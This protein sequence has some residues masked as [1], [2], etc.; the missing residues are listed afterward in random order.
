LFHPNILERCY[1]PPEKIDNEKATLTYKYDDLSKEEQKINNLKAMDVFAVGC[2]LLELI[3]G[4]PNPLFTYQKMISFR[5][6]DKNVLERLNQIQDE[7]L[8]TMIAKMVNIDPKERGT[9]KEH[10]SMFSKI[11]PREIIDLYAYMNYALRRSEFSQP[12]N[13]LALLR[14]IA[15]KFI[16]SI[17]EALTESEKT[18]LGDRLDNIIF[19]RC[20]PYHLSKVAILYQLKGIINSNPLGS[21]FSNANLISYID[22]TISQIVQTEYKITSP[23][24]SS[25]IYLD[26]VNYLAPSKLDVNQDPYMEHDP[27]LDKVEK[28]HETIEDLMKEILNDAKL[29][30]AQE[31]V[32]QKFTIVSNLIET[33]CSL[34]RNLQLSQSYLVALE[35][36][37]NF[38]RYVKSEEVVFFIF[39]HLQSQV[40]AQ[41]NKIEKYYSINLFCKLA[42]RI[43]YVTRILSKSAAYSGYIRSFI[44]L[45]KDDPFL[46]NQI[47]KNIRWF[48]KLNIIFSVLN[49]QSKFEE[50]FGKTDADFVIETVGYGFTNRQMLIRSAKRSLWNLRTRSIGLILTTISSAT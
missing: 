26:G 38:S 1:L 44:D 18:L 16:Q 35:L 25:V 42:R 19:N 14:M 40:E 34:L 7:N 13:K 46:K 24:P 22:D 3:L 6:G 45:C 29:S 31:K 27:Y 39:P 49:L 37:D 33:T 41:S 2:I 21:M 36:L 17:S 15:P 5:G 9:F 12:D 23:N 48:I 30:K 47:F 4:D 32:L 8:R 43:R 50:K 11:I 20:F 10:L 28:H